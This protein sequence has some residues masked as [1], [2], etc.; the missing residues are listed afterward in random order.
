MIYCPNCSAKLLAAAKFCHQCGQ[1]LQVADEVVDKHVPTTREL[2]YLYTPKDKRELKEEIKADFFKALRKRVEEEQRIEL[3]PDYVDR[4]YK[5][6]FMEVLDN[7]SELLAEEMKKIQA[8]NKYPEQEFA[9]LVQE[10]FDH[11][12]DYLMTIY[13]ADINVNPY[14]EAIL[15]YSNTTKKPDIQTII[16]DYLDLDGETEKV[17]TDFI[18]MPTYKLRN[19]ADS[20]LRATMEEKLFFIIDQTL[21]GSCK[22]GVAM[23]NKGI[24]WKVHFEKPHCILFEDIR[25]IR[26]EKD[27][28][29]INNSYF[30]VNTTFNIRL[31]KL[32]RKIKETMG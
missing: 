31:M 2:V 26:R 29:L 14:P 12:L 15:K 4:F 28:L 3:Y 27:W 17:F 6:K 18:T 10:A 7:R 30:N 20:F 19:A 5:S 22:E 11:L 32:L 24:Y 16:F 25:T 21:L 8:R 9:A 13:C 23:T 1:S